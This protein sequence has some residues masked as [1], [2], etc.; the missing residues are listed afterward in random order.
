MRHTAGKV[1]VKCNTNHR[2]VNKQE[3]FNPWH[4]S[5]CNIIKQIVG[6][7]KCHFH[8]LFLVPS[9]SLLMQHQTALCAIHN[10]ICIHNLSEGELPEDLP[11][12]F[13]DGHA[14][15]GLEAQG[16]AEVDDSNLEAQALHDHLTQA[17]WDDYQALLRAR[18][19]VGDAMLPL[20]HSNTGM[21]ST[22]GEDSDSYM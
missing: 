5:A 18:E 15:S 13:K 19:A 9:F 20:D 16:V 11:T 14:G 4:A 1:E 22:E 7:L 10:F 21:N 6:V 2:L 3:L 12:T 17:M 8:I